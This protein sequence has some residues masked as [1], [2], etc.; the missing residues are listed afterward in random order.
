MNKGIV[1]S[2]GSII[3]I[4]NSGDVFTKNA[5]RII[6]NNLK[7]NDFIFGPIKKDR[8][9]FNFKPNLIKYKFNIFPSHSTSFFVKKNSL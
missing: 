7:N 2:S 3:G 1:I 9:L 5:I 6:V 8:V 4:I